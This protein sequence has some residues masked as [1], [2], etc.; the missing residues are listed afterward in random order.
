MYVRVLWGWEQTAEDT[1]MKSHRSSR[2]HTHHRRPR[3]RCAIGRQTTLLCPLRTTHHAS[4]RP[5]RLAPYL[6][7]SRSPHTQRL[8]HSRRTDAT[9]TTQ[10]LCV[11]RR[12]ARC[13]RKPSVCRLR[14]ERRKV[15]RSSPRRLQRTSS[16]AVQMAA[17]AVVIKSY[18]ARKRVVG[19]VVVLLLDSPMV[20]TSLRRCPSGVETF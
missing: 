12:R 9:W 14:G 15:V 3:P 1:P 5:P 10:L 4:P 8:V 13:G 20:S 17:A 19:L 18:P 2:A 11:P 7:S 16:T 6:A